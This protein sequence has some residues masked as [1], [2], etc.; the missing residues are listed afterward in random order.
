[1]VKSQ[2]IKEVKIWSLGWDDPL[3]EENGNPL[4]YA[5]LKNPVDRDAWWAQVHGATES[6]TRLSD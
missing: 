5:C 3:E 4:Q 1:M 6:W 2:V